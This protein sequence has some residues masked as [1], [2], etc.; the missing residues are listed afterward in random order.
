M[1]TLPSWSRGEVARPPGAGL[2]CLAT[3]RR[4]AR[5][6]GALARQPGPTTRLR[7]AVLQAHVWGTED[8]QMASNRLSMGDP[9][10]ELPVLRRQ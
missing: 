4:P 3:G 1:V 9:L 8:H 10:E 5:E 7:A 6:S 2:P